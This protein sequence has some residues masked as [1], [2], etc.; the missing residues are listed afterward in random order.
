VIFMQGIYWKPKRFSWSSR[1]LRPI[2]D[3]EKQQYLGVKNKLPRVEAVLQDE[4]EGEGFWLV[5]EFCPSDD[6][7]DRELVD[8]GKRNGFPQTMMKGGNSGD[9]MLDQDFDL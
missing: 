4:E 2:L 6:E 3:K 7:D 8:S 1:S 9:F 5:P